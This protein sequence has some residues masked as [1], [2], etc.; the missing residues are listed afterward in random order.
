VKHIPG[1]QMQADALSRLCVDNTD[2]KTLNRGE[3]YVRFV[4]IM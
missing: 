1:K 4:A 2:D 3:E